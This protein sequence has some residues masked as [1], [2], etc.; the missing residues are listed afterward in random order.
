MAERYEPG[1]QTI[2]YR[3]ANF[4]PGLQITVRLLDPDFMKIEVSDEHGD[5]FLKEVDLVE[6]PGLYYFKYTFHEGN[7]VAYFHEVNPVEGTERWWV[8]VYSIRWI[9]GIS[10]DHST[11]KTVIERKGDPTFPIERTSEINEPI[12][13]NIPD[14]V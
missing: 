1:P 6:F 9:G 8:Q 4:V 7:Y 3:A 11:D 14:N 13:R 5:P 2:F 10:I 12:E